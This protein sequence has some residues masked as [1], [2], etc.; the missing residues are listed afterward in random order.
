RGKYTGEKVKQR[1]ARQAE[2]QTHLQA[3]HDGE[4]IEELPDALLPSVFEDIQDVYWEKLKSVPDPRSPEKR[5]YPL[6]LILHRIIS[7]FT[8]GNRYIGV[9]FPKKRVGVEPGKK[10]LGALPTRKAVYTLLRRID[11]AKANETLAPLWD[12]LGF[13]PNLVVRRELRNPKEVLDEF[14]EE[15][16]QVE[17]ERR[18]KLAADREAEERSKGMSAAKAKRSRSRKPKDKD[19]PKGADGIERQTPLEP[20][21]VQHDLVI[22]GKVVKASYNGGTKERF[23]HVTEIRRNEKEDRSRFIIGAYPTELDRNGE[24]G[25]AVS[26]LDALTPLPGDRAIVVSG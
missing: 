12:R 18:K 4:V 24:W 16:K 22:D 20:I 8:E 13:T 19:G 6:H 14:R 9:L 1:R 10:K 26:I 11:W 3:L 25:A 15:R 2:R 7:G 23:V 21:V 5:I 17:H